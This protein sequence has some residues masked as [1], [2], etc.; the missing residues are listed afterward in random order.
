MKSKSLVFPEEILDQHLVVLG[1]T[2][3][4]KS[5][6]LRHVVE[7]LLAKRKRV[8]IIDPKGDWWGLKVGADGTSAGFPVV[9]FGDFK[10]E[11]ARDVPVNDHS[12]GQ[13]A[14]LVAAG[15]R[16]CVVGMRGWTQGAM[17]R[18]WIAFAATLFARNAGEF[19]LV[20]DEFHNFAPK[21]WKGMQDKENPA[22]VGLH[23]ANR[24][25]AEGRGL[26]LVCLIA[27]QRP[28]KV[29]ND[30]LTSC[31]TLVA[32]RVI[33]KADRDAVED[34][35][36]GAG[37]PTLGK[38][39]LN[40]LAGMQRG[41]AY[42]WSP[43][44]QFGPQRLVFPL[45]TTFDS[46]APP[47]LQKKVSEQGWAS[48]D[49]TEVQTKLA[50][51]IEQAKANDPKELQR[52]LA[53]LRKQ[54]TQAQTNLPRAVAQA[55]TRTE[56]KTV[57]VSVIKP[58]ELKRVEA[59]LTKLAGLTERI[60][61]VLSATQVNLAAQ[62]DKLIGAKDEAVQACAELRAT[63][64]RAT[65]PTPPMP[66]LSPAPARLQPRP[67]A[68]TR[69]TATIVPPAGTGADQLPP[70]MQAIL[71]TLA[72]LEALG[73]ATPDKRN[74]AVFAGR[75]S[76]SSSYDNDLSHLHNARG[77]IWYP[78]QGC[79]ALTE[80]GRARAHAAG[81]IRTLTD[82]HYAWFAK[83][84]PR[85]VK[86]LQ[87]LIP[88]YPGAIGKDELALAAERGGSSSSYDN[89]LSSLRSVGLIDYPAQRQVAATELLF[90]PGLR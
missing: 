26:G 66:A 72:E 45:F 73:L 4:G 52:Q 82:L 49:L 35:I 57:E 16:P 14:E 86:L 13:I 89:D 38:E 50:A 30:T 2:G 85:K 9:L 41:A 23:W 3:A 46:F 63:L 51:V 48:V 75:G 68:P 7:H 77:L 6:A 83:L 87:V 53:E 22:A 17:T 20:G 64:A 32:M 24:L 76:K 34:W 19:Y 33:H 18:F 28:Q 25:L 15:N 84:E 27:S 79:L 71:N 21:Q 40:S 61:Q 36:K 47:Q 74:V 8:C 5:S 39:V 88:L 31:E 54:L 59:A 55:A 67:P 43:E 1:K 90:P 60:E 29:H 62:F 78:R 81:A 65:Q 37:D 80:A 70:R 42:V 58:A 44:A 12:G 11:A 56:T 69:R 10:N